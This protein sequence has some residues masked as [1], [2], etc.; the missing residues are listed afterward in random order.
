M[1]TEMMNWLKEGEGVLKIKKNGSMYLYVKIPRNENFCFIYS[2]HNYYGESIL[3]ED[4]KY[5]GMYCKTDAKIYDAQYELYS[6]IDESLYSG[7]TCYG[8]VKEVFINEVKSKISE[9]IGNDRSKLTIK[10]EKEIKE[11]VHIRNLEYAREY[12]EYNRVRE[13]FLSN[14]TPD[15]MVF[16]SYCGINDFS[17]E[18]Y[19]RYI[20]N[21]NELIDEYANNWISRNQ[22]WIFVRFLI[23][24]IIK[25]ELQKLIDDTGNPV[26][27]MKAVMDSLKDADCKTVNVTTV[28]NSVEFTF[29]TAAECLREDCGN[30]Y[31]TWNIV[32]SDRRKFEE[33]YGRNADY[34]P[35]D[36]TKITYGKKVLYEVKNKA[37]I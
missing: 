18:M 3:T 25:E 7:E 27:T 19:I 32:A 11:D 30:H 12:R 22:E 8:N 33:V 28:I 4:F 36:I 9:I 17:K 5:S 13:L 34:A 20:E 23:N 35:K 31:W 14:K 26:H 15:D 10:D 6:V 37:A 29:K 16:D 24:D 2:Q 21:K 1:I